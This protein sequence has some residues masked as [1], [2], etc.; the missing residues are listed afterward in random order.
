MEKSGLNT[1]LNGL[2]VNKPFPDWEV[3]YNWWHR[4]NGTDWFGFIH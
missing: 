3:S 1:T 4:A 2:E